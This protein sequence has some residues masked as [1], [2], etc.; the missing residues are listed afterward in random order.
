MVLKVLIE[1]TVAMTAIDI[2]KPHFHA[3]WGIKVEAYADNV[4]GNSIEMY[5][6]SL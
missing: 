5:L 1:Y 6:M 4:K 2:P 3:S